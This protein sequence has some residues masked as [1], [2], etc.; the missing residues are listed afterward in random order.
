[1]IQAQI[2]TAIA[3]NSDVVNIAGDRI[4]PMRMPRT[5]ALPAVI[6]QLPSMEPVNSMDGDSGIDLSRLTIR[7]WAS[8]YAVAHQ[9]A[10]AVRNALIGSAGFKLTTLSQ[11]DDE[12]LETT[13]F[14]VITEYS[15]WSVFDGGAMNPIVEMTTHVFAGD[16]AT[17]E[18][19]FPSLF[20]AGTLLLF[21]N[22]ALA[23]KNDLYE[24]LSDRSGVRFFNAPQGGQYAD[25]FLAFYAKS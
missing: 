8:S 24:E 21:K 16:D 17:T 7:C 25:K 2:F 22:G 20:R 4:F 5:V 18:F 11:N 12:D 14:C 15:I 6:Y 3:G 19:A 1:M 13:A 9:L 23:E 10:Y